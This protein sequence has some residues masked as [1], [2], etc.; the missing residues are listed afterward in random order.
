MFLNALSYVQTNDADTFKSLLKELLDKYP[1]EDVSVLASE[2]M[3]GFQRG[4]LLAASGDN[5]LARGS[6]F[7]MRF[8]AEGDAQALDSTVVFSPEPNTPHEL[9][10]IYPK[11]SVNENI[12]LFTVASFNFGN[13][14]VNDFDL[15][16]TEAGE[17]GMLQIKGFNN[18]NEVLQYFNMIN[19]PEGYAKDLGQVVLTVPI[20]TDNYD[21]LMKGKSLGE[22]MA[23]FEEHFSEGNEN[24][25]AQWKLKQ[26]EE[27]E[28]TPPVE[29]LDSEKTDDPLP[30]EE[31]QENKEEEP[32]LEN[33]PL[34]PIPVNKVDSVPAK[35]DVVPTLDETD[36][37]IEDIYD[38]ASEKVDGIT[39]TI[40]EISSDPIRGIKNLFTKK[41]SSNAIDEYAKQQE[42]EE[43]ERLKQLKKEKAEK[44]KA[45]LEVARQQ[46]KERKELL[47]KQEAE[48]NALLKAQKKQETDN[49]KLKE[50]EKKQLEAD[51]KRLVKEKADARK[52]ALKIKKA[53]QKERDKQRK[54]DRERM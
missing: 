12:L 4:L 51:K 25:I 54:I 31:K 1:S 13:F 43:K 28:T 41:K 48:D 5:M 10:L 2:M 21:I 17:A 27:T 45:D 14:M 35:R 11:G 9:L 7:N 32:A 44:E 36:K 3:K 34:I 18:Q 50:A 16:K 24:L 19:Q 22:Y 40:N 42:K 6:L 26:T 53:E 23:F 47:K 37:A 15:E 29:T 38:S 30:K 8:G 39:K 33:L 20:S 52:E 49:A 46:E